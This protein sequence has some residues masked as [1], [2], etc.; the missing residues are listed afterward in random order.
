[1]A[2][3]ARTEGNLCKILRKESSCRFKLKEEP[4]SDSLLDPESSYV[5]L[6]GSAFPMLATE[7]S[8]LLHP[9]IGQ[10]RW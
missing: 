2:R 8:H 5:S 3:I 10:N 9:T 7:P 4:L 6:D 1:M